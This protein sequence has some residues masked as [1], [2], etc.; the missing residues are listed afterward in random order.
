M[1]AIR[2]H[3]YGDADVLTHEDIPRP[4]P[5]ADELLVRVHAAGVN[6]I[7]WMVREGYADN[8][9][10]PSLPYVPG[11]DLSGV[12]ADVGT[13]VSAFAPGDEV[14]GLVGMPDPGNAYAEYATVP[15]EDVVL[16]SD[17]LTH[18][19]AAAIPMVALTARRALFEVG[20]VRSGQ[21]VLVHAAAGGVGHI[22]VQ[23]A[24][25]AGASVIGTA[26][27]RNEGFLRELGVDEFVD[28]RNQSFED[29]LSDIDVILDAVGGE[30][31]EQSIDV[32]THGGRIVTLP[33][34]PS[35]NVVTNAR[36]ERNASI[37]WFSVEP[38]AAALSEIRTLV[39]N[40]HL[41]VTV[42]DAW[43]LSEAHAAHRASQRG[44]V[45]GK[46]VLT[47]DFEAD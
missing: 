29:E 9:L 12:V 1:N 2:V 42:S 46:L 3:E 47:T 23:L 8:A 18:E 21:R 30:T 27:A 37:D 11:W 32:I 35:Q 6:P 5:A 15:A 7:D 19:E 45:R 10:D 33:K 44:H 22:A 13:S 26:S 40:G 14:F 25:H 20:D 16:K 43:P 24:S 17:A 38:D 4:E 39:E 28:Y 41:S 36:N 34:P 31:L